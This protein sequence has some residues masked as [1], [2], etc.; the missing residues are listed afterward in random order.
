MKKHGI[1]LPLGHGC[2]RAWPLVVLSIVICVVGDVKLLAADDL[3]PNPEG[4]KAA[5]KKIQVTKF[6]S[7]SVTGGEQQVRGSIASVANELRDQLNQLCGDPGR[8]MKLPLI[9]KLYGAEGDEELPRSILSKISSFQGQY[10]LLLHIHL[11]K[12]VDQYLLRYHLVELFLYERGLADGQLVDQGDRVV[13][14]PWL[15]IGMLEAID[16]R[17]GDSNREIYQADIDFLSIL[18]LEKVFDATENQWREMIGREPVAFRA[19][20]GAIV[21]SLLRQPDGKSGMSS[22]LAEFATFK[23]EYENLLRRHFSGMNKS[24]NSLG[25]W[26]NLELLEL[27]TARVTQVHSMLETESR[28]DGLLKLRY[29]DLD[30][31]ALSVGIDDYDQVL[32]LEQSERIEAVAAA[33][34]ELERL[35]YR[36]FPTYRPIFNEYDIILRDIMKGEDKDISSRLAKLIDVRMRMKAAATRSRDYLDWYYITQSTDLSGTF[37]KYRALIEALKKEELRASPDDATSHYLDQV[38]KIYGASR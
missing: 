32:K 35:S 20:S 26:V 23:G 31:A 18:P 29:R 7:I 17:S 2:C 11:A 8:K 25:K 12:G 33:R 19:I 34:A 5:A 28:L 14:K 24:S 30:G 3:E 4:A 38:Q 1:I 15:I 10:Q 13:I 36:C 21:N 27:A 37:T 6:G 22:Y 16:I 9:V